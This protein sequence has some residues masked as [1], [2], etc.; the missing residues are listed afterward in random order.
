MQAIAVKLPVMYALS[1]HHRPDL[2]G[3]AVTGR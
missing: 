2:G 3:L 1:R